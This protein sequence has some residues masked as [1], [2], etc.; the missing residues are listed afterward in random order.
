MLL[1]RRLHLRRVDVG[2]A[3]EDHVGEAVAEEEKAVGIE[4]PDVAER[5]PAAR[6]RA[7]APMQR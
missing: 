3:A 7:S 5:L 6:G 4:P 2:T 1:Q